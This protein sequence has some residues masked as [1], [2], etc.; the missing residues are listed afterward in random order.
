MHGTAAAV[1]A[2]PQLID[3]AVPQVNRLLGLLPPDDQRRL[4]PHLRTVSLR[5]KQMLLRHGQPVHE[6]IFPTGGV[7][8]L[9]KTTED[10]HSIEIMGVGAEGAIGASIAWGQAESSAD[11]VVQVPNDAALVLP[12]EVFK[13][14]LQLRAA[15]FASITDYCQ[16]FTIQ[17]MQITACNALHSAEERCCRWLLTTDDRIQAG[18]CAITQEMLAMTLGVRRP[19]VT[20]IMADLHRSGIVQYARGAVRIV[21]RASL[22]ARACECYR[23]L[24]PNYRVR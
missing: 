12:L 15:L 1:N 3:A 10:G 24:S 22:E 23:T 6:I 18:T 13:A 5:S 19:T 14:E 20:H 17:L 4:A 2:A 9:I 7:C 21:D 8:S 16:T 11:V